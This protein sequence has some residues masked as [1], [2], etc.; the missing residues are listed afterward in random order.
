MLN[1]KILTAFEFPR[2]RSPAERRLQLGS[3]RQSRKPARQ[4][5]AP[6]G[7][8]ATEQRRSCQRRRSGDR[9]WRRRRGR[10]VR[11]S[12]GKF[13]RKAPASC[14]FAGSPIVNTPTRWPS[15]WGIPRSRGR[16]SSPMVPARAASRR[17]PR[18]RLKPRA[19]TQT[20]P[21]RWRRQ[22]S[23]PRRSSFPAARRRTRRPRRPASPRSSKTSAQRPTG[24]TW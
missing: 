5:R 14:R 13:P 15:C 19:A 10:R 20:L 23:P 18:S 8:R 7:G 24:A 12:P 16:S 4:V 2:G 22:R 3:E 11:P 6:A 1:A 17:P 9:R 21:R